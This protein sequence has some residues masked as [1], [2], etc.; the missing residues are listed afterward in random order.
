MLLNEILPCSL[1]KTIFPLPSYFPPYSF[2]P[3]LTLSSLFTSPFTNFYLLY[4][5]LSSLYFLPLIAHSSPHLPSSRQSHKPSSPSLIFY[6]YLLSLIFHYF[7]S[8]TYFLF[9]TF[10]S[11]L[12]RRSPFTS[13]S[14]INFYLLYFSIFSLY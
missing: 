3:L 12:T 1:K 13:P 8:F 4:F 14:L 6:D 2:P 11:L 9:H 10:P 7:Y 5:P